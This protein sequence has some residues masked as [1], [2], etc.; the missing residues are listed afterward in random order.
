MALRLLKTER[1][2]I[3]RKLE[4]QQSMGLGSKQLV[5]MAVVE[6]ASAHMSDAAHARPATAQPSASSTHSARRPPAVQTP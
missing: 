5:V 3:G 4:R 2:W 1:A 6:K